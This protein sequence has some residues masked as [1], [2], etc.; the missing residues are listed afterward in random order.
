VYIAPISPDK[1]DHWREDW[2]VIWAD[3]HDRLVLS[4]ESPMAMKIAW[5]EIPKLHVAY[6]PVIKRIK[7]LTSHG[8]SVMIETCLEGVNRQSNLKHT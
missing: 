3:I 1:W 8:L 6:G 7:H 5:E 2:V 4:T